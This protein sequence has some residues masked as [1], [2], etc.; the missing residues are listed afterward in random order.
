VDSVGTHAVSSLPQ[1]STGFDFGPRTLDSFAMDR[2]PDCEF[3]L[4]P[5]D[6]SEGLHGT[7]SGWGYDETAWSRAADEITLATR[8][9]ARILMHG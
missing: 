6:T 4:S 8:D 7:A 2:C 1:C 5:L 3:E 9:A